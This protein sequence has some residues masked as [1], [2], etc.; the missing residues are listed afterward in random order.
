M[1]SQNNKELVKAENNGGGKK[2]D[3]VE[4]NKEG[5]D[6][7]SYIIYFLL[8]FGSNIAIV[9]M[10][11]FIDS[12]KIMAFLGNAGYEAC[13]ISAIFLG[14]KN[15]EYKKMLFGHLVSASAGYIVAQIIGNMI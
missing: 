10:T 1:S 3:G 5:S 11:R 4:D 7:G 2:D 15:L 12:N 8:V 14:V 9:I 13:N 6:L